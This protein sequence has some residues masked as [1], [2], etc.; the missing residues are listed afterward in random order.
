MNLSVQLTGS[1]GIC[2]LQ[3]GFSIIQRRD[4]FRFGTDAVLLADFVKLKKHCRVVDLGAG[5]GIIGLL[6]CAHNPEVTV[7]AVEIQPEMAQLTQKNIELNQIEAR[8]QA[9][10]MDMRRAPEKLG[11][12]VYD[13]AV[14]NPPYYAEGRGRQPENPNKLISRT[15]AE[16]DIFEI[17]AVAVRLLKTGGRL[18]VVYPAARLNEMIGAMEKATLA[19]K[20]IRTI[21]SKASRAPKLVLLDAVKQGGRGMEWLPPLILYNEDGS[22]S[23]EWRRIYG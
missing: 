6:L 21:H 3:N 20:R 19:P 22:T 15:E 2:D 13:C 7:S 1:E 18:A 11:N 8:M 23:E 12:C 10:E 9:Y 14:C 16:I 5:T 17:C 4:A